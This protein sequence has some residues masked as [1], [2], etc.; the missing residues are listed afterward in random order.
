MIDD[1][2]TAINLYGSAPHATSTTFLIAGEASRLVQLVPS[3]F[4]VRMARAIDEQ[5]MDDLGGDGPQAA[6]ARKKRS[7]GLGPIGLHEALSDIR[8]R[9]WAELGQ[10]QLP[11]ASTLGLP[12]GAVIDLDCAADAPVD[13]FVNGLAFAQGHLLVTDDG[14]W[15]V[16]LETLRGTETTG[17]P[18]DSPITSKGAVT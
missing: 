3:A 7:Q 12:V 17:E 18:G 4:V 10:T 15:A 11:L 5:R 16:R 2:E 1:T 8:L 9:V 14:E 13:L 6:D